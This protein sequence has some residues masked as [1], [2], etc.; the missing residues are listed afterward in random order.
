M[1][2]ETRPAWWHPKSLS[3]KLVLYIVAATCALTNFAMCSGLG[4]AP[5][6]CAIAKPAAGLGTASSAARGSLL[7]AEQPLEV[8][9]HCDLVHA[10][11]STEAQ[12]VLLLAHG[13][14]AV[15][16]ILVR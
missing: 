9:V 12:S 14:G 5:C 2:M 1:S 8:D 13:K 15:H 10:E 11:G 4:C 3:R 16:R 7:A 6:S